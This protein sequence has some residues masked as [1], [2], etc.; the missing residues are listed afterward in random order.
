[1]G[2]NFPT[3]SLGASEGVAVGPATGAVASSMSLSSRAE[4][5]PAMNAKNG[6]SNQLLLTVPLSI[7]SDHTR[8]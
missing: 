4:R 6:T 7:S 8:L 1:M 3:G 5:T 2:V